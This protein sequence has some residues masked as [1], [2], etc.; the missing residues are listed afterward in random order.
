MKKNI[1]STLKQI[2][3]MT[4]SIP[5]ELKGIGISCLAQAVSLPILAN[6]GIN[7]LQNISPT[8]PKILLNSVKLGVI[9]MG[10]PFLYNK[11]GASYI[12][13]KFGSNHYVTKYAEVGAVVGSD[14]LVN[15]VAAYGVGYTHMGILS[16][17]DV[18]TIAGIEL[19]KAYDDGIEISE[20][21]L[22]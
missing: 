3:E 2:Y 22:L 20:G 17:C 4:Q 18:A 21:Q 19:Y 16:V 14:L 1:E 11:Y 13:D 15:T 7:K 6:L 10:M 12:N 8:I 5:L 9:E